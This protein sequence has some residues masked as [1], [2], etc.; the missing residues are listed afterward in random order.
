MLTSIIL[1]YLVQSSPLHADEERKRKVAISINPATSSKV[2]KLSAT[3][4][5]ISLA[6]WVEENENVKAL[7]DGVYTPSFKAL[8]SAF[9]TQ[10]AIWNQLSEND[11]QKSLYMDNLV[12]VN[13]AGFTREYIWMHHK[14]PSWKSI[15]DLKLDEFKT[16]ASINITGHKELWRI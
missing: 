6:N 1:L 16:W 7:P 10:I 13:N 2:D 5:G 14:D 8:I 3:A 4:F 12:K 11:P 15:N 9:D